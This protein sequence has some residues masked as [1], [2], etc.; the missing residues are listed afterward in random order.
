MRFRAMTIALAVLATTGAASAQDAP[1]Q[2]PVRLYTHLY[3]AGWARVGADLDGHVAARTTIGVLLDE[4]IRIGVMFEGLGDEHSISVTQPAAPPFVSAS[5]S[6]SGVH[7]SPM[8]GIE[9]AWRLPLGGAGDPI[10]D[11]GAHALVGSYERH[12]IRLDDPRWIVE[13]HVALALL[14]VHTSI[15]LPLGRRNEV[16]LR[17]EAQAWIEEDGPAAAAGHAGLQWEWR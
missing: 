4:R 7:A 1:R 11:L 8:G 17:V 12:V 6:A 5:V 16:A 15:A 10:V 3:T 9:G 13:E 14:G 2:A